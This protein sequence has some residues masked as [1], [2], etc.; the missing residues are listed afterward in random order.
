MGGVRNGGESMKR[1]IKKVGTIAVDAGICWVGDPSYILHTKKQPKAIGRNWAAFCNI[2]A[3]R[4][5][6]PA[7]NQLHF[8]RGHPGLGVVVETGYGDGLYPVFA[9]YNEEGRVTQILVLFI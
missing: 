3:K 6:D 2:L 9:E 5:Q 1:T 7:I 4:K 8:D